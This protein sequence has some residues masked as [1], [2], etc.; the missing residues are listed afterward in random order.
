M[1]DSMVDGNQNQINFSEAEINWIFQFNALSL[2]HSETL[3]YSILKLFFILTNFFK[4]YSK[5]I[6]L[7]NESESSSALPLT[8]WSSKALS[9]SVCLFAFG[10]KRH[11]YNILF[12]Y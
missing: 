2:R 4:S 1:S 5:K 7:E 10:L 9:S 11:F 12:F 8:C 3:N 6:Q